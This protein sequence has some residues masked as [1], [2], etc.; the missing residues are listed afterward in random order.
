MVVEAHP[1]N[2]A[3]PPRI[4]LLLG[5]KPFVIRVLSPD[6]A[7]AGEGFVIDPA[8]GFNLHLCARLLSAMV[9]SNLQ[10]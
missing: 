5:T 7:S 4:R 9:A 8:S 3:D 10:G 6:A 2:S 1:A